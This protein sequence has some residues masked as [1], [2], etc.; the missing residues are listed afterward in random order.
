MERSEDGYLKARCWPSFSFLST[1]SSLPSLSS[2][3]TAVPSDPYISPP[4]SSLSSY[5][6]KQT[7]TLDIMSAVT[8]SSFLTVAAALSAQLVFAQDIGDPGFVALYD[9]HIPYNQIVRLSFFSAVFPLTADM[10]LSTALPG[11]SC[12]ECHPWTSNWLQH[13]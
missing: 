7:H 5:P 13:L 3:S 1:P 2:S 12:P 8:R 11:R 4:P 9:K 10:F 6:I